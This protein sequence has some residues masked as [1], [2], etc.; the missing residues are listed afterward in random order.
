MSSWREDGTDLWERMKRL[1]ADQMELWA[2]HIVETGWKSEANREERRE[3]DGFAARIL[4]AGRWSFFSASSAEQLWEKMKASL[5]TV[6]QWE[7]MMFWLPE[8]IPNEKKISLPQPLWGTPQECWNTLLSTRDFAQPVEFIEKKREC[9]LWNTS[10]FS[11]GFTSYRYILKFSHMKRKIMRRTFPALMQ[12]PFFP[13]EPLPEETRSCPSALLFLPEPAT[14]LLEV[15]SSLFAEPQNF[16]LSAEWDV[17]DDGTLPDGWG[18]EAFDGEGSPM[19]KKYVILGGQW[20]EP[21][22]DCF[23]AAKLQRLSTGNC[24]R[25]DA[26]ILPKPGCTNLIIPPS[27]IALQS[28]LIAERKVYALVSL[29]SCEL[30]GAKL[31]FSGTA[32]EYEFS[33]PIGKPFLVKGEMEQIFS[34]LEARI[35]SCTTRGNFTSPALYFHL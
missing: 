34:R 18:T 7:E 11:D 4:K 29:H 23:T 31:R 9:F 2:E 17:V 14:H 28:F 32:Q 25:P 12:S 20:E 15:I 30:S 21:I 6:F 5:Y 3:T 24:I 16:P 13:A 19:Q 10:G 35:G 26:F 33:E 1:G 27:A 8:P 22:L